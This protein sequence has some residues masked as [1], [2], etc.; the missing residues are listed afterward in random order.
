MRSLHPSPYLIYKEKEQN[1]GKGKAQ[2]EEK[3]VHG[4]LIL[5]NKACG[6]CFMLRIAK[7]D[8]ALTMYNDIVQK[9][10]RWRNRREKTEPG[11]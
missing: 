11:I 1:C 7:T 6:S 4:G 10:A 5:V 9:S 8:A 3:S 2:Q